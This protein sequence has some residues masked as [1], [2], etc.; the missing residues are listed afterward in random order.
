ME[1]ELLSRSDRPFGSS[2][3]YAALVLFFVPSFET[4][5]TGLSDVGKLRKV[6]GQR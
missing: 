1:I 2:R 4:S 5:T 6:L 3:M